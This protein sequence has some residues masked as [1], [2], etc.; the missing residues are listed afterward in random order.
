[1]TQDYNGY[2]PDMSEEIKYAVKQIENDGY[3]S[4]ENVSV[5][6]EKELAKMG[7]IRRPV[8]S[9]LVITRA[10]EVS[11]PDGQFQRDLASLLNSY[12]AESPSGTPDFILSDLLTNILRE[13]NEA[14]GRRAEWRGET[15]EFRP[16]HN[17]GFEIR[18]GKKPA[19]DS[20]VNK[21]ANDI[22]EKHREARDH[23]VDMLMKDPGALATFG[24]DWVVEQGQISFHTDQESMRTLDEYRIQVVQ[25]VRFRARPKDQ[26]EV[27][28][29]KAQGHIESVFQTLEDAREVEDSLRRI[30]TQYGVVTI[31]DFLDLMGESASYEDAIWG[32]RELHDLRIVKR[33]EQWV[34][35]FPL[36]IRL[37][38]AQ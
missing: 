2:S 20:P 9:E 8:D 19:E 26:I 15:V 14:V 18:E 11:R 30:L 7:Y 33:G 36:E 5:E 35:K 3:V 29:L 17:V 13:F 34:M 23:L 4:V 25:E 24:D 28:P 10:E 22:L 38:T 6:V 32:W 12:S 1:M 16:T 31:S 37:H 27:A 21:A